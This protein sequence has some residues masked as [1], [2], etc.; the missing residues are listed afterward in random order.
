M[1]IDPVSKSPAISDGPPGVSQFA[2]L[3]TR[4]FS[5]LFSTHLLGAFN[6]ALLTTTLFM[7][8]VTQA[9]GWTA[10]APG[11]AL[12]VAAA[13]VAFPFAIGSATAGQLADKYDKANLARLAKLLEMLS[14]GIAAIGLLMHS[15]SIMLGAL[16]LL[17]LRSTLFVPVKGAT[18]AQLLDDDE[19]VGGNALVVS[20]SVIA[21]LAGTLSG[22]LLAG[23]RTD[24]IAIAA[25]LA[26]ASGFVASLRLPGVQA[27]AP[28]LAV[29]LNPLTQSLRNIALARQCRTVW[30]ALLG[31]SLFWLYGALLLSSFLAHWLPHFTASAQ[32]LAGADQNPAILLLAVLALGVVAGALL[33][34]T[35]SGRQ[36]EI[37]LLPFGAMGQALFAL[38]LSFAL[39]A[40]AS[41]P[42]ALNAGLGDPVFWRILFDLFSLGAFFGLFIV[43]LKTLI[44]LRSAAE[45]RGRILCVGGQLNAL[46]VVAGV[47]M[48]E[49]WPGEATIALLFVLA[50]IFLAGVAAYSYGRE[51]HLSLRFLTEVVIHSFYRLG[52]KGFE[53]IPKTG[54]AVLVCNHVSFVD[55]LVIMAAIRRPIRFVID[56]RIHQTP[57]AGFVFR[58]SR[59]IPIATAKEDPALKEAAFDEVARALKKG[60]LIGLFPEGGITHTGEIKHFRYGVGRIVSET[61]VPVIPMALRGLWGSFFS[62]RHGPAMSRPSL[63]RLFARI[64]LVVGEPVP[65]EKGTPEY[66]QEIVSGLRGELV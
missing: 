43:S 55:S 36:L 4:R 53:N 28:E 57:V 22:A 33:C 27:P 66:L 31:V 58:H 47:L 5:P 25:S 20:S 29:R 6:D 13:L 17:G 12:M 7:L 24:W 54:P 37:G 56:H 21:W 62:R 59:T 40:T 46:A 15:L 2:L 63:M 39:P 64:E 45:A 11:A 38:D 52:K 48:A 9:P 44:Q 18:L 34:E 32:R 42:L 14:V 50:A 8:L 51:P 41:A 65:P 30:P 10:L 49:A 26:A 23:A 60:E 1:S 19:L 16:G 3:K 61:P 35:L